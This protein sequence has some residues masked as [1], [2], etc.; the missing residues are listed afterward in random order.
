MILQKICILI[1][2]DRPIL[3]LLT[4]FSTYLA[5]LYQT[6]LILCRLTCGT[7][8][9]SAA[10]MNSLRGNVNEGKL[11]DYTKHLVSSGELEDETG[12][13]PGWIKHGGL[14]VTKNED[15]LKELK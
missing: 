9:H 6:I 3:G 15:N 8:W 5:T 7:T 10:M 2:F 1:K 13:S 11:V 14:S 4:I 12:V